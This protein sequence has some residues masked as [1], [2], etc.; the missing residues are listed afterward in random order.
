MSRFTQRRAA[1]REVVHSD[2]R[3]VEPSHGFDDAAA[4]LADAQLDETIFGDRA[5]VGHGRKRPYRGLNVGAVVEPDLE[6]LATDAVLELV[7]RSFGD[8]LAVV[9][10]RDRVR[11]TVRLVQVLGCQQHG[12][13]VCDQSFDRLPQAQP[14]PRV[15]T[16]SGLVEE[17]HRRLGH[18]SI[19]KV[20]AAPHAARI[21]LDGP[22]GR[23]VQVEAIEQLP[24]ASLGQS[25]RHSVQPA[26]HGQVLQPGEVLVHRCVLAGET[27]PLAQL[28]RVPHDIE[29]CDA[30]RSRIGLQ[31][32]RQDAHHGRLPC[33]V[34]TE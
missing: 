25:T 17:Q 2:S 1:D 8:H 6:P 5:L 26:D 32:R 3:L 34:R 30:C 22:I 29:T 21:C 9:D 33:P 10:H 4:A 20:E 15:E 13:A 19:R 28:G 27:D 18:Q 12:R 16:C 11:Q 23:L 7:G 31:Q 24:P 14:A